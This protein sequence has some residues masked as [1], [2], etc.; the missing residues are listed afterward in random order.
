MLTTTAYHE[1]EVRDIINI[2][3]VQAIHKASAAVPDHGPHP[4]KDTL[5]AIQAAQLTAERD[6]R[7][8]IAASEGRRQDPAPVASG[9]DGLLNEDRTDS[10]GSGGVFRLALQRASATDPTDHFL[11]LPFA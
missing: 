2:L 8:L 4:A 10:C 1:R 6:K 7:A 3:V 9:H 11:R 5:H